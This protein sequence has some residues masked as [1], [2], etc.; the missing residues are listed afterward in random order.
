MHIL[1]PHNCAGGDRRASGGTD[2]ERRKFYD[3]ALVAS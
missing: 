1:E 3:R 2:E